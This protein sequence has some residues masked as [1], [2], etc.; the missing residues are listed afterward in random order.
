MAS[1]WK[2]VEPSRVE[3]EVGW[4]RPWGR[5]GLVGK[6]SLGLF[7]HDFMAGS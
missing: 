5:K 4:S 7:F 6:E 3:G 1:A 2:Q